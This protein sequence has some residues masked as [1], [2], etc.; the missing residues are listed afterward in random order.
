MN[1]YLLDTNIISDMIR[2]PFGLAAQRIEKIDPKEIC[3]SIIV[4]CEL[5]Y[6]CAKKG[7]AKLL[8]R[9][10]SILQL[11][12]VVPLYIPAD[13]EYGG[14]RAELEAAGQIIGSNDLLIGAHAYSLGCI[15]VTDNIREFE[16]IRGLRIENWL[17]E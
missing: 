10:E 9:V 2:N 8:A 7:S 4:A 12:P 17:A 13:G 15:L 14:I 1:G 6:G 3:T 11:I 16:R 5:R